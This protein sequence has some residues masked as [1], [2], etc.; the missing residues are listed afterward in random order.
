MTSFA[1]PLQLAGQLQQDVDTYSALQTLAIATGTIKAVTGQMIEQVT[2]DVVELTVTRSGDG[3]ILPELPVTD[4]TLVEYLQNTPGAAWATSPAAA[5]EW[6]ETGVV[7][8][9]TGQGVTWPYLNPPRRRRVR[10]TYDHGYPI[11]PDEIVGIC[12]RMAAQAYVVPPGVTLESI[13]GYQVRY[14]LASVVDPGTNAILDRYRLP[15]VA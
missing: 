11:I 13:G 10:V 8:L 6:D 15:K 3:V 12:L 9:L 1:T 2:G 4:V 7:D 5:Y 14:E